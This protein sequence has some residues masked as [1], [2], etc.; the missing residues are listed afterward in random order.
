LGIVFYNFKKDQDKAK[1]WMIRKFLSK[2][3]YRS[4]LPLLGFAGLG[5]VCL[6]LNLFD[7]V[8]LKDEHIFFLASMHTIVPLLM[9][10]ILLP[11]LFGYWSPLKK[12]LE[13]WLCSLIS[14]LSISIYSAHF[15]TTLFLIYYRQYDLELSTFTMI[16]LGCC[17]I[18]PS[19]F[20]SIILT[21]IVEIPVFVCKKVFWKT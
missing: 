20:I 19:F 21:T 16:Y 17:T 11:S 15:M 18:L 14:K 12:M 7:S 6:L 3:I 8:A 4:G 5:A 13:C 10:M 2:R 9:T 1:F